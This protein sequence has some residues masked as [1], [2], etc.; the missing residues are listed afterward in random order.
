MRGQDEARPLPV[1]IPFENFEQRIN[2]VVLIGQN[3]S[4]A[5]LDSVLNELVNNPDVVRTNVGVSYNRIPRDLRLQLGI[6]TIRF[7]LK[8]HYLLKSD[9][10][11][12]DVISQAKLNRPVC[13]YQISESKCYSDIERYFLHEGLVITMTSKNNPLSKIT[14]G[15]DIDP[16]YGFEFFTKHFNFEGIDSL[17]FW[18][19]NI[20]CSNM[21]VGISYAAEKLIEL[22][23]PDSALQLLNIIL[24]KFPKDVSES[25]RIYLRIFD[26]LYAIKEYK[27]A[28]DLA[29]EFLERCIPENDEQEKDR[30]LVMERFIQKAEECNQSEFKEKLKKL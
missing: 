26:S 29:L 28:N 5:Q 11:C 1:S 30:H 22:N 13:F 3:T 21:M 16:D 27:K 19:E 10:I 24:E 7:S 23:R 15:S 4:S 12:L 2:D 9:L 8:G 20:I 18:E 17:N 14:M 25:S 6:D